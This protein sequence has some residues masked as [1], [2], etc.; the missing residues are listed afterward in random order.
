MQVAITKKEVKMKTSLIL[1]LIGSLHSFSATVHALECAATRAV[2]DVG[3]GS[4]K[5]KVAKVDTCKNEIKE[6]LLDKS[7]PVPYKAMLAKSKDKKF[8]RSIKE[9]GIK[10]LK[11]LKTI[12]I[13][14]GATHFAGVATS[15]FRKAL[16]GKEL[17]DSINKTLDL[18]LVIISQKEEGLIGYQGAKRFAGGNETV[19]WDIG[20]GS[21]QMIAQQSDDFLIYKGNLASVSFKK[22]LISAIQKKDFKKSP[23]P[24][25]ISKADY[26]V[27]LAFAQN[28]ATEAVPLGFKERFKTPKTKVYGIGGVHGFSI[29][30][31]TGK[32]NYTANDIKETLDKRLGL[33]DEKIGGKY[34]STEISN[35]ILVLGYMKSLNIQSV[36]SLKVNLADGLL[37]N[38][39]YFK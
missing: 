3:S 31:Q 29:A 2:F 17:V 39:K 13:D 18:N 20:G 26:K 15:A 6:L 1:I 12:A 36:Q 24:N 33:T 22:H 32:K 27:A 10:A 8:D 19:V 11:K 35:L 4:T 28:H 7:L 5:M 38:K 9:A 21:M 37:L 23:S 25:P 34:A 30:G 14:N 16:N